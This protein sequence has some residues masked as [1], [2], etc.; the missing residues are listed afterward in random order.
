MRIACE[1]TSIDHTWAINNNKRNQLN[2]HNMKYKY[3]RLLLVLCALMLSIGSLLAVP[4]YRGWQERTLADGTTITVRL[5]GD[6]FYHF[7]ETQDGKIA[8]EQPDGTF[9][10]TDQTRPTGEQIK[11]RRMASNMYQSQPRKAVGTKPN[12]APKGVVILANFKDTKMQSSH[13]QAVFDELCNATNCTVNMYN[14]VAY[15]SAAQYFADQSNGSYRPQFDVFGPV[16]LS[17]NYAYYGEDVDDEGDDRYASQAVMEACILANQQYSD[18]DFTQYDSDNDG[19]VDFVYVIYAGKGQADGGDANTIWPHN[20]SMASAI[21]YGNCTYTSAQCKLD[22]KT[23]DNYACS[24]ELSGS[25]LSGIGT[26]CHEFGHVMGLPDLYDTNY[27]TNYNNGVTPGDWNIMDG[28]S[29]NGG[30]HCPP[31]YDP[32]EKYFFGWTTPVNLGTDGQNITLY[33]NGT[34]N[35]VPYQINSSNTLQTPTTT[36]VVYY[37]ENRQKSGWDKYVPEAGMLV[38]KV[39][40]NSSVWTSNAPNNTAGSPRYTIVPAD[41]KTT[42]YASG[43][44]DTYPTSKVKSY[45][46]ISG[47]ELTSIAKSGSNI[48]FLYNGGISGHSVVVDATGCTA[49]P[50]AAVVEN[51]TTLTVSITPTDATYDYT[52]LSVKLGSTTLTSGTHYTLSTDKK[53][54]TIKATAITGDAANKITITVVWTKNRYSYAMLGENCTEEL[55]GAVNKNAAL[56]LTIV[57]DAGYTLADAS[58]W[59]VEMDGNTLT[60]G[61]D[62]TYDAST[63]TFSI[64]SVIGDM[65]ILAYGK[66]TVTWYAMG[67]VFATNMATDDLITLPS[68]PTDCIGGKKFVGWCTTSDYEHATTAPTF[69]KNGDT[70]STANYYAVYATVTGGGATGW[71]L[72]TDDS[73]LKSGDV[74][75]IASNTKGKTAG[76]ISSQYMTEVSSTFSSDYSTITTLGSNTVELTLGGTAGAWTLS[77]GGKALGATDTKKLAWDSGTTTWSISISGGNATIQNGM[78][79]YGRFLHNASN[80]PRFTTYGSSTTI[81]TSMLLPQ[82]YRK[83]ASV[84]Y[85]DYTT[86]CVICELTSISL[87]TTGVTTAFTT[88]DSFSA[89]GLVVTANYSNCSAKIVTPTNISTP[90]MTTDGNK[91]VT[92]TYTENDVTKTATYTINV[93]ALVKHTVTWMACGS[94]FKTEQ[95]VD[96]DPLVLPATTPPA[97]SEGKTFYG[98]IAEEHYSGADAPDKITAGGAVT[99]DATYYAVYY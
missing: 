2:Q 6:E 5:V 75:V 82:L 88:D 99:A 31:N 91:T 58:C 55:E 79:S 54:L 4:A 43:S 20:W 80:S 52:S 78:S 84:T 46:P 38:W 27:G 30:G 10:V 68:N 19:K 34:S 67:E 49:V 89:E 95:Y 56:S 42:K 37:L 97:N 64:T 96:G 3:P 53:T 98:W 33:A 94:Q 62:F 61:T 32:W 17:Q 39:D 47:H 48:T 12:L 7:W 85:S 72:V 73:S 16:T 87:N 36:G 60:Y 86:G 14:S 50:S 59:D 26:L 23:V 66:H 83:S 92:V 13:T 18:L 9:V 69:A 44:G 65:S 41:G 71:E 51:G 25:S 90:D 93:A 70:Y 29:Y 81:S 24:G 45:T 76:D 22:G 8:K 35:Y 74:L 57:P 28:G 77:S 21:Y 11:K 15:G 1:E 63:N 40:F